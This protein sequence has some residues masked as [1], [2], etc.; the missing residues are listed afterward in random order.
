MNFISY[1]R[2]YLV[3]TVSATTSHVIATMVNSAQDPIMVYVIAANANVSPNG[4]FPDTPLAN[5]ELPMRLVSHLMENTFINYVQDMA[6]VFVESANVL[7]PMRVNILA[8]I[9]KIVP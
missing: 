9:A 4:T 2:S 3:T 5:A 7:K 6:N 8:D 1:Y